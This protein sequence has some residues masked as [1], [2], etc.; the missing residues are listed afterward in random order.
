MCR[1]LWLLAHRRL[2]N[3]IAR[4][5]RVRRAGRAKIAIVVVVVVGV[6]VLT[7]N[8]I[9]RRAVNATLGPYNII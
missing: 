7:V 4:P 9:A 1:L 6:V 2:F 5:G 8:Q 3:F